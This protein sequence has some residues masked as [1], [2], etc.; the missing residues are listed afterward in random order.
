MM[1]DNNNINALNPEVAHL[2]DQLIVNKEL[3][4]NALKKIGDKVA[5]EKIERLY[6]KKKIF[7]KELGNLMKID[8]QHY[9]H[10]KRKSI[11]IKLEKV[12]NQ[13][14]HLFFS[15]SDVQLISFLISTEKKLQTLY[16]TLIY[17]CRFDDF[18]LMVFKN[19]LNESRRDMVELSKLQEEYI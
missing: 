1:E 2:I 14:Q 12:S 7:I 19:Q 8:V 10:E 17:H 5:R 16:H 11:D 3:N 18:I 9:I 4:E 6:D 15:G 13:F